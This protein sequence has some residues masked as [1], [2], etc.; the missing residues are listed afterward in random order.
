MHNDAITYFHIL[1]I[2]DSIFFQ[3]R[4]CTFGTVG[5]LNSMINICHTF[6]YNYKLLILQYCS[7][8]LIILFQKASLMCIPLVDLIFVCILTHYGLVTSYG[9]IDLCQHWFR[10][11]LVAWY[12]QAI[13]WIS[14]DW[15]SVGSC[16]IHLRAISQEM[17]K[18]SIVDISLK[19]IDSRSQPHFPGANELIAAH[20]ICALNN[21]PIMYFISWAFLR[22]F[23]MVQTLN[24][25]QLGHL[26]CLLT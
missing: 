9:V 23:V 2:H 8:F 1:S 14:V 25:V 11:W 12:V 16:N 24:L 5:A 19:S 17:L 3:G 26:T 22:S 10:K 6:F 15:S 21:D 13:S 18:I 20:W 7:C 4:P